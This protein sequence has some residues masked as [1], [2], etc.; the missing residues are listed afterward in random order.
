[1]SDQHDERRRF[2][3]IAFDADSEILQGERR[4][5]VLLHDVSGC[6]LCQLSGWPVMR[7]AAGKGASTSRQSESSNRRVIQVSRGQA[8]CPSPGD[9]INQS[10]AVLASSSPTAAANGG[11]G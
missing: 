4:W 10:M 5:E 11:I 2:H 1:M 9:R 7:A 3:R 8:R 6:S